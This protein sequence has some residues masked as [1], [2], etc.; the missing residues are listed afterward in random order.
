MGHSRK[1]VATVQRTPRHTEIG[2]LPGI[3][4]HAAYQ[5]ARTGGDFFDALVVGE[6]LIF[7]I[8][9]IAG[10]RPET[11][12]VA[13][14]VQD[15]FRK[16]AQEIFGAMDVNLMDSIA[17]LA[18]E[19]NHSVI[20]AK[21][22]VCFAPAFVG[23]FDLTLDVMAYINAGGQP[24]VFR[25][26]DGTRLLPNVSVPMGLF[27]HLVYEPSIQAFVPGARLLI[28]TK[29]VVE[30]QRGREQFGVER[31]VRVVEEAASDSAG[32][33][34]RSVLDAA[35]EF[36]RPSRFRAFRLRGRRE[37]REDMTAL[38]VTRPIET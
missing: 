6:R 2:E 7:L 10:R 16:G 36:Q 24:A 11:D 32:E 15:T 23:C 12:T 22:S 29:G 13:A 37:R 1:E 25:D 31:V 35:A 9:D 33:L 30:S 14:R 8:M 18:H 3:E 38:A 20:D 5:S 17:Q 28:V 34:C 21:G 4:L 19:I 27:T 26:G